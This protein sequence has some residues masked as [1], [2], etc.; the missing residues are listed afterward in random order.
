LVKGD[1]KQH[2]AMLLFS[3]LGMWD[4]FDCFFV[5]FFFFN[6]VLFIREKPQLSLLIIFCRIR[7]DLAQNPKAATPPQPSGIKL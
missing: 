5:I 1:V 2:E 4:S 6:S 7:M 3:N